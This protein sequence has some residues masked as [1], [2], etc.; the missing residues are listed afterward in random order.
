M[1]QRKIIGVIKPFDNAGEE[2]GGRDVTETN[3]LTEGG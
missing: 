3:N 1:E 2:F